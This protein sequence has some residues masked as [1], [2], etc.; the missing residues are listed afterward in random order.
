MQDPTATPLVL[1]AAGTSSRLGRPKQL[2]PYDGVTL[3]RHAATTALASPCRPVVVVI[4]AHAGA[5]RAELAGLDAEIVENALWAEGLSTSIRFGVEAAQRLAP[6]ASAV[7][8]MLC[9]QPRV[10][11][12]L[13]EDLVRAHHAGASIAASAYAGTVGVPALFA[14]EFFPRLT[15]LTRDQGAKRILMD[16]SDAVVAIDFP[17]G[18]LDVDTA[19][20]YE[21]LSQ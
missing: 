1:L 16:H 14:K 10:T 12:A 17:G 5:M 8:L 4:G 15:G 9:D 13:I 6:D 20:D 21:G 11:T 3:L 7:V 19:E 2:L 18:A